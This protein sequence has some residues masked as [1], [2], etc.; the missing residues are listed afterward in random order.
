MSE[1]FAPGELEHAESLIRKYAVAGPRYTSYPTAVEF[2]S[3]F[4]EAEWRDALREDQRRWEGESAPAASLY[5]H[6]PYCRTLCYF[7]ACN[8]VIS[9]D[10]SVLE[11]YLVTLRKELL[12]YRELLDN[13]MLPIEQLHWGGGSPNY[14][15]ADDIVRLQEY[16]L[17]V[18]PETLP[19]GDISVELDPRTTTS[20]QIDALRRTGFNRVSLGVQD[21][22]PRVQEAVNRI[23]SF[24]QTSALVD[25]CRAAG[26]GGVN[27]DLIYG[28]SFQ[29]VD[30]FRRT[31]DRVLE[32]R[33]DR[34]ALYGYAHVT[35]LQKV[36][37]TLERGDLPT[38]DERIKIF[39]AAL[40]QFTD[41]GYIYI[42]LDH[43]ALPK[44]SLSVAL[45]TGKLNR[46]F[47]GYTSHRGARIYGFGAS[48]ISS[49]PRAFAQNTKEIAAYQTGVMAGS[50]PVERGLARTREDELRGEIIE[51]LLCMGSVDIP[52]IERDYAIEFESHFAS[53]L[54][55][56]KE[57]ET[58]GLLIRDSLSLR[59][60]AIGR[61]FAR[62]IAMTFD[63]YLQ[64]HREAEKRVFSQA[65]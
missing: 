1:Q 56:L 50:L 31:I 43:F 64:K 13:R 48:A 58:D 35:W 32:I 6:L 46:N 22:D 59:V 42:G 57:F 14:L 8:K 36:Q 30:G 60:T 16:T 7:C 2:H 44:D 4:G 20:D 10:R 61:L 38:P 23:Q 41:A 54:S 3:G 19:D 12:A 53:T 9:L 5:F 28:L 18:F 37:K 27:I 49:L 55:A 65:I 26:F 47:M 33:P 62:N 15:S 34:V 51:S 17:E 25:E 63:A 39:T 29:T 45:E 40:K 24:E 21:F 52:R 11:P